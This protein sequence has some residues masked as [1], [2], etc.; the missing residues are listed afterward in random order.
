MKVSESQIQELV[1]H[2]ANDIELQWE[3]NQERT[4]DDALNIIFKS[5]AF[6]GFKM[7]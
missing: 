3:K 2:L 7:W 6:S 5:L 1:D 4:F